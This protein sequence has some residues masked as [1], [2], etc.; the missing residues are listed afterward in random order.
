[1]ARR[2]V[3]PYE[4][5]FL[6]GLWTSLSSPSGSYDSVTASPLP[7]AYG[8]HEMRLFV[9]DTYIGTKT[10]PF[11][12]SVTWD[13]KPDT[14]SR[15]DIPKVYYF[16]RKGNMV[17]I[18]H[19]EVTED[20]G[21]PGDP[22]GTTSTETYD[23]YWINKSA[24]DGVLDG[25]NKMWLNKTSG[26]FVYESS[27]GRTGTWTLSGRATI[28]G[29]ISGAYL[30]VGLANQIPLLSL[31]RLGFP[32]ANVKPA[33]YD[34][35]LDKWN[36]YTN[37]DL[38]NKYVAVCGLYFPAMYR[39]TVYLFNPRWKQYYSYWKWMTING[40]APYSLTAVS[41]WIKYVYSLKM[42]LNGSINSKN[43]KSGWNYGTNP[44]YGVIY[45]PNWRDNTYVA[46]SV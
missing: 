9:N 12:S 31:D 21:D 11:G 14:K 16:D 33:D 45:D 29:P 30:F 42:A 37:R 26:N 38:F 41:G 1:M 15:T 23:Y 43:F 34:N 39:A 19:S 6:E 17:Y 25:P 32:L 27:N 7:D 24:S 5:D 13:F 20:A 18:G 4:Y 22:G 28:Y 36:G 10:E 40:Q 44:N 3:P 8:I 46:P 35:T 2:D